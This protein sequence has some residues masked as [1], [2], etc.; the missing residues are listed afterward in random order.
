MGITL[1]SKMKGDGDKD[2]Y[3]FVVV[4]KR[5]IIQMMALGFIIFF[6][7]YFLNESFSI[8][9]V[10]LLQVIKYWKI[11]FGIWILLHMISGKELYNKIN[12]SDFLQQ[13]K[14]DKRK[15]TTPEKTFLDIIERYNANYIIQ[16][17]KLGILKSLT[18][19][20]LLPLI[21]GYIIEGKDISVN[22]NWYTVV[23][24]AILFLYLYNL[25]KCYKNMKFWKLYTVEVQ[26]ELRD[27]QCQDKK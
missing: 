5:E 18:P 7:V 11:I 19:I 21:V 16:V 1:Y 2:W 15:F 10:E 26:K 17:E 13:V 12:F 8:N 23:F 4:L 6:L 9:V 14:D 20:S 22:W 24:F 25:W 3:S 27:I